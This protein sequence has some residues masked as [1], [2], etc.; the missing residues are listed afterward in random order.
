MFYLSDLLHLFCLQL[1][2]I[3]FRMEVNITFDLSIK[4]DTVYLITYIEN[5]KTVD[6]RNWQMLRTFSTKFVNTI[7]SNS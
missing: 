6:T 4:A 7:Q 1:S 3:L 5:Y 2:S